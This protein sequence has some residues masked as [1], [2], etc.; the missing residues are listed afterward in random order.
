[1][2]EPDSADTIFMSRP[3]GLAR[4]LAQDRAETALWEPEEMRAIWQHQLR[5][6]LEAD[7]STMHKADSNALKN[8]PEAAAFDKKNFGELLHH[9]NP[10]LALLKLTKDFAKQTLKEA[11]DPQLKET[12]AALYYVSYAAGMVRRSKRLGGMSAHELRGGFDWAL[13]RGWLDE[14]SKELITEAR[15]LLQ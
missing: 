4:I 11:E 7:F 6:P 13:A 15:R 8:A 3:A 5:A 9:S 14:K 12:A 2:Q 1:M 10:P